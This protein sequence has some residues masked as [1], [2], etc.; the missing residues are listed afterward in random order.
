MFKATLGRLFKATLGRLNPGMALRIFADV[1]MLQCSL[2]AALSLAWLYHVWKGDSAPG[3]TIEAFYF[4]MIGKWA[5][6]FVPLTL[7]S[8]AVFYKSGFYTSGRFY[9]G[10]YKDGCVSGR[11]PELFDLWIRELWVSWRR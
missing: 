10:R 5:I 3:K 4:D 6:A 8:I 9:Q 2:L 1:I 7:I 11:L